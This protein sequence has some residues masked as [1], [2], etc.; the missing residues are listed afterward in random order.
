[1][2]NHGHRGKSA[3]TKERK[4]R[5][6]KTCS[7][8]RHVLH[9]KLPLDTRP[10]PRLIHKKIY[11][12]SAV[13]EYSNSIIRHARLL[14]YGDATVAPVFP[15]AHSNL[16]FQST[17]QLRCGCHSSSSI[18]KRVRQLHERARQLLCGAPQLL[19]HHR[20]RSQLRL[21]KSAR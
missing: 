5:E 7:T 20:A 8:T 21:L 3:S 4:E 10:I 18:T 15:T 19:R 11:P 6:K 9:W 13:S 14:R 17:R 16:I 2:E 1:M 12:L